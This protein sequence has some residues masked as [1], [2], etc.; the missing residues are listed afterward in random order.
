MNLNCNL[1]LSGGGMRGN[2][3][4]GILKSLFEKGVIPKAVSG[5]SSG[6]LVGAFICDGF[7]PSEVEA[8]ILKNEPQIGFNFSRFWESLLSFNSFI[9]V[10]KKNLRTKNIEDLQ[11]PLYISATNLNTG[12]QEI[13]TRGNIVEVLTASAA[14]PVLLP[15]VYLNSVPYA[16][17]GMTNNLPVEPFLSAP[18]KIIACHVNPMKAFDKDAGVLNNIDR[19]MHLMMQAQVNER[20]GQCHIFIEPP[21]LSSFHLFES[22]KTKEMITIGYDYTKSHIDLTALIS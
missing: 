7:H 1:V 15:P 13:I 17:G 9:E 18:E 19:S 12:L 22:K 4:V 3:H 2:A 16:D 6:A 21:A 8:I 10:L 14:I 11:L 5:T 20:K